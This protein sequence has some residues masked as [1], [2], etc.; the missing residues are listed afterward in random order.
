[1]R[2]NLGGSKGGQSLSMNWALHCL[3]TFMLMCQ[4]VTLVSAR[5]HHVHHNEAIL[6]SRFRPRSVDS[7]NIITQPASP[8]H[9]HKRRILTDAIADN[10]FVSAS[11]TFFQVLRML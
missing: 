10:E 3:F 2:T 4:T 5:H 6:M 7:S 9:H 11:G 1:M 8:V